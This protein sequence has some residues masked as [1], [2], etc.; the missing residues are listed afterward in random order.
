MAHFKRKNWD[1][2]AWRL[3]L[4]DID[5]V[6]FNGEPTIS[7]NR[8][9]GMAIE[10][11]VTAPVDGLPSR[12]KL[13][14]THARSGDWI[15]R[16]GPGNIVVLTDDEFRANYDF[17]DDKADQALTRDIVAGQTLREGQLARGEIVTGPVADTGEKVRLNA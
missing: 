11:T 3:P 8:Q 6:R 15:V 2:D 1:V 7:F 4:R 13:G 14:T 16:Q 10:A 9:D 5:L 12:R 17:V